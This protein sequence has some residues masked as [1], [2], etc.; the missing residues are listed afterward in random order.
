MHFACDIVFLCDNTNFFLL[1]QNVVVFT[2]LPPFTGKKL[3][4]QCPL[5]LVISYHSHNSMFST[6]TVES[7]FPLYI[8]LWSLYT[9]VIHCSHS[10]QSHRNM[11]F[12]WQ[13]DH[14]DIWMYPQDI[15]WPSL[16]TQLW[17]SNEFCLNWHNVRES[18]FFSF[19]IWYW[20]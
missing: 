2:S 4:F 10:I 1:F 6:I 11:A 20:F 13:P 12:L 19:Q 16:F 3:F 14:P 18:I 7:L 17:N 15:F 9:F 8:W 5:K